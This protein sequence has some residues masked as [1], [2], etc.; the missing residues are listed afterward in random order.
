LSPSKLAMPVVSNILA[1]IADANKK[2]GFLRENLLLLITWPI[3]A[4]IISLIGWSVLLSHLDAERQRAEDTALKQAAALSRSYADHL[5]R[6]VE[7][8]D[9]ILL[10]VK[11]EWQLS[12]GHLRMENV[13]EMG[14]FPPTSVLN[15]AI[16]DRNGMILSSSLP[17][18]AETSVAD[19]AYFI[20]Q[21]EAAKDSLYIGATSF[22]RVSNRYVIPF[23][24][25][26]T[27]SEGNFA[28]VVVVA[29]VPD[30]LTANYDEV[31]LGKQ[32]LLGV[33][34]GDRIVRVIRIGKSVF[35][36]PPPPL[37]TLPY[38]VSSNGSDLLDGAESFSDK[39][40]R[41]VGWDSVDAYPL[42]ALTGL[43]QQETLAPYWANRA[44]SIREAVWATIALAVFT[45][46]AMTLSVQLAWRKYKMELTQ[47]TYR[48]ATEEGN[49]GFYIARPIREL[50]GV[51]HDFE[52][53]D[54][55]HRGAELLRERRDELI[56]KRI[57]TLY[58]GANPA[59]LTEWLLHALDKGF[60]EADV[61]VPG[62]SPLVAR[63]AHVKIVR[64][65]DDLAITLRD[66]S[67]TKAHVAELERRGNEDALTGLP[68]RHWA[69][70]YVPRA[71]E[72][73]AASGSMLALLFV[74]L[75]GFKRVNDTMGHAAGDE[76]LQNAARRLKEAVRPHDHAVRLGG[77]EF[78][79][80][81]EQIAHKTDAAHV[82]ERVVHAFQQSFRLTQGGY[83]VG[84]SI[85]I[86]VFPSDGT[87]SE[88]LLE[89]ADIAMYS[90]KTS[91]K[92]N[93]RFYDE[94]FYEALRA[95]LEQE[96]E[97]R[98]AIEHDEFVMYYQPRVDISTGTTSSMEALVRWIHPTRG[99]VEPLAFIPLAE[100]T[101]LIL[102]LGE[103]V[104]DKVCAQ[105]AQWAKKTQEL[106]PVSVNVSS[107]QFNE[108]DI[109]KILSVSLARHHIDARL[110][111][112]EV[113]ESSMMGDNAGVASAL[114]T[115]RRM[116]IKLLVDDFGT[117]YSSLSQ[118]QR[119][120]FD[121][122]KVDRAFTA[123]IGKT[124]RGNVFFKAIITMAHAIGMRVVAEGV[125][126]ETQT[127]ILK[128]LQCDE[129]QGFYISR[130]L[131]PSDAQPILPRW[132]FPS[133]A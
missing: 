55:N 35:P 106:V 68:N 115:I 48:M 67:E 131:P 26:L 3:A 34:G 52:V 110:V 32:G 101:G 56:G 28:G 122:L 118:L 46:I 121:M 99:L 91:G 73:A 96:A 130:P 39:R 132:F 30:Y 54:S 12:N 133:T 97:L 108:V 120:D 49:E 119:L 93:Y 8:I 104:I 29:L 98:H 63:W 60:Y 107:R 75:D 86:S 6:T 25:R 100:E 36:P 65:D 42:T 95:R 70:T 18:Q 69:Q 38:F 71:I 103:L 125:E 116:G 22:S 5:S 62:D 92:G 13:K 113:T 78:L 10:H 90:V 44:A 128:S 112:V 51:I 47:A 89:N 2:L 40:S 84:T 1:Y 15:V 123:E 80:I 114:T 76:L 24:R 66:I 124:E 45:L 129:L 126:N 50:N 59:R 64:A 37:I 21:Q 16:V 74:D 57:S 87:D 17:A 81:I 23:T 127:K 83:S 117:G 58:Q 77:D 19:R 105:L 14:L 102:D 79:V 82:A 31:T 53:I 4:L 33:V 41:Y 61:E 9:Q 88:T 7:S 27:D 11:Y 72:H 85:G 109:A 43:D 20:L 111:E 94:K